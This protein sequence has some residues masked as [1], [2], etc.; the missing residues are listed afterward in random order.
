MGKR[1][2]LLGGALAFL[3]ML[4]VAV[5]FSGCMSFQMT[6]K[7]VARRFA[8]AGQPQPRLYRHEDAQGMIFVARSG[9][10]TGPSVVLVHGSPGSWDSF[11][12]FLVEPSLNSRYAVTAVDRPGFGRSLP[13]TAEPSLMAQAKRIHDAV[14]ASGAPMPA[15][16]V[17]HSLGGPVIARLAV[18]FPDAVAG[19]VLVAPSMDPELEKRRWFNW[20]GKFPLVRWLLPT[21]W[22]NSN[23]EI[24]PHR[25]ELEALRPELGEIAAPAIVIQG[26]KDSLVPPGNAAYVVEA[27][28]RA[29]VELRMLPEANHFIPWTDPQ[30]IARAIEDLIQ[31]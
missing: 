13:K 5:G 30:E 17:G 31:R 29:Q 12:G 11:I 21:A 24:F 26:E 14:A 23:D 19:L 18:D 20:V 6:D 2:A 1:W 7:E 27:L 9:Q 25:R 3:S 4:S 8:E 16:W 22:R 15:I 28:E 10:H